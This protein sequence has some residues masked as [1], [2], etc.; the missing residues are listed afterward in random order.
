MILKTTNEVMHNTFYAFD[1]I[2]E[3]TFIIE[4]CMKDYAKSVLD[5]FIEDRQHYF[6]NNVEIREYIKEFKNKLQ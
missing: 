1:A 6:K 5:Q 2:P 4:K 3:N